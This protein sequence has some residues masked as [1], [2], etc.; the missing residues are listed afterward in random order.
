MRT[1]LDKRTDERDG[2]AKQVKELKDKKAA[3][4][5]ELYDKYK[6]AADSRATGTLQPSPKIR[7]SLTARIG[8]V[9]SPRSSD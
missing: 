8:L 9:Q 7:S 2:Y 4:S 6:A 5:D 3:V 1:Q